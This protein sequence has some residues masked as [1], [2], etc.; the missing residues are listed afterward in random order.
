MNPVC[1]R[2]QYTAN[3][4]PQVTGQYAIEESELVINWA[5]GIFYTRSPDNTLVT[6]TVGGSGGGSANIVE[7]ATAWGFP[8][9]G[10]GNTIYISTD[11]SRVYRWDASGVYVEI[12]A[13][14]GGGDGT[15][16]VLRALFVPAAPTNVTA[17]AG[18]ANATITWTA[19]AGVIS[20]APV[21]DYVVQYSSNSGSTW[22][23]F[24]D[25]TSTNTYAVV[26]GLTNGTAYTFRVAAVNGAGT[27]A[28]SASASGTPAAVP[29]APTGL[30]VGSCSDGTALIQWNAVTGATSYTLQWSG[31]SGGSYSTIYTGTARSTSF[32]I[33]GSKWFRVSAS[34][35][36]GSS[37][38]STPVALTC[39]Y[40][41]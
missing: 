14:G 8:A 11:Y 41:G 37:P 29:A 28:W 9:T 34:N 32:N 10:A 22:T 12:G 7:A 5:D 2:R 24:A 13:A 6:L 35:S 25:G 33:G 15:D 16:S 20:Q 3:S 19:P 40:S 36:A 23:T 26:T 18:N 17:S 30:T 4:V 39:D 27:G 31:S 38:Y 1:P 21:T